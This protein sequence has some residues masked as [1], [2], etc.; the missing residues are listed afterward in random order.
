MPIYKGLRLF[1]TANKDKEN[2]FVNGMEVV[3]ETY[4]A[5]RH[6]LTVRTRTGVRLQVYMTTDRK[7]L[8]L[9]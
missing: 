7:L 2:D 8:N 1:L 9:G 6:V 5:E 4:A 3:V